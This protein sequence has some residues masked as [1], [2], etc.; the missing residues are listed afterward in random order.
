M[1]AQRSPFLAIPLAILL[2]ST[3][4]A[5]TGRRT[6]EIEITK[7]APTTIAEGARNEARTY[8]LKPRGFNVGENSYRISDRFGTYS[9]LTDSELID[10]AKHLEEDAF[11]ALLK[12]STKGLGEDPKTK[13][14]GILYTNIWHTRS[15]L[16]ANSVTTPRE[17]SVTKF[18]SLVNGLALEQSTLEELLDYLERA[19]HKNG[20][21]IK[22]DY[23]FRINGH[24]LRFGRDFEE[25]TNMLASS[26]QHYMV[27]KQDEA[28]GSLLESLKREIL[29]N[30]AVGA[31]T[32]TLNSTNLSLITNDVTNALGTNTG[33]LQYDPV[34][35]EY[36]TD[37]PRIGAVA[38]Y[39][40]DAIDHYR[41]IIQV[42]F[43]ASF[44]LH[45]DLKS[46]KVKTFYISTN[47]VPVGRLTIPALIQELTI[48]SKKFK[49]AVAGLLES[50]K[51]VLPVVTS[52]EQT[53]RRIQLET[54][55]EALDRFT[56]RSISH[57]IETAQN[58]QA[59]ANITFILKTLYLRSL[60]KSEGQR[61]S[62]GAANR[63]LVTCAVKDDTT[64]GDATYPLIYEKEYAIGHFVNRKDRII[65]GPAP[66]KGHAFDIRFTALQMP[67]VDNDTVA[68]AF[69]AAV[70]AVGTINPEFSAISPVVSSF[71]GAIIKN[72]DFTRKEF[73]VSFTLP[74]QEG[75]DRPDVD[76]LVTETGHYILIKTE[77]ATR[78]QGESS[79]T[80]QTYRNLVYNP[81]DGC[82]YK[83]LDLSDPAANFKADN[84]F[85]DQSYAV[86][87]A[88]D[89]YADGSDK[90]GEKLREQTAKSLGSER[91][92]KFLPDVQQSLQV[93]N[94]FRSVS[95][96]T[97]LA[98]LGL[99][100]LALQSK[101]ELWQDV[102]DLR[103][104]CIV[105]MLESHSDS[106][107]KALLGSDP[108]KWK[109][110]QIHVSEGGII[111][112]MTNSQ[113]VIDIYLPEQANVNLQ[114][115][116][117]F[118]GDDRFTLKDPTG[119]I[120]M[121]F[122][123]L[124]AIAD[125]GLIRLSLPTNGSLAIAFF[126]AQRMVHGQTEEDYKLQFTGSPFSL[127]HVELRSE[128]N[129][130]PTSN[131]IVISCTIGDVANHAGFTGIIGTN[132]FPL[133]EVTRDALGRQYSA[134]WP[135]HLDTNSIT[136][137]I[138][139]PSPFGAMWSS[140]LTNSIPRQSYVEAAKVKHQ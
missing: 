111:S 92:S 25:G 113:T 108:E 128:T 119:R 87:V 36:A 99:R 10:T 57:R 34:A 45:G 82:L 84:L 123:G 81:E 37:A 74:Q 118:S 106:T 105:E 96:S 98:S 83:R 136:Q 35:K 44:V 73:D 65:F 49:I 117:S 59:P 14:L 39:T 64:F 127:K 122:P 131:S 47:Y 50:C 72:A 5:R 124:A 55:A 75:K 89:E 95:N 29:F 54:Y 102:S 70:G 88:T 3:S 109:A 7:A 103:K 56:G 48:D 120:S 139:I 85:L 63:L 1:K 116:K 140:G 41:R 97:N 114:P 61:G 28:A 110:A 62:E 78:S 133:Q 80:R 130:S 23:V 24:T 12:R 27:I 100:R 91:A 126:T 115:F 22:F 8:V 9:H 33:G 30:Y 104:A 134:P 129:S 76:F 71:F 18:L 46:K 2:L 86:I 94:S 38:Q 132:L 42:C 52:E 93:M 20:S 17:E 135:R 15:A 32:N 107:T 11:R 21:L 58:G 13:E 66:Y 6:G 137:L 19:Y 79:W 67:Y 125:D 101:D 43:T 69:S 53:M 121:Q 40:I 16:E 4:C 138:I 26:G 60:G 90:L 31:Y 77:D 112:V 68:N 51:K